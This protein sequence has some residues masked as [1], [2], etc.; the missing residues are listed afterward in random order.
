MLG[1]KGRRANRV[2][3]P[4]R[5]GRKLPASAMNWV[6]GKY[7]IAVVGRFGDESLA[8][9]GDVRINWTS[10]APDAEATPHVGRVSTGDRDGVVGGRAALTEPFSAGSVD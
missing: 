6:T 4:Q 7:A 5:V 3:N 2:L 8:L 1:P 9:A 10:A